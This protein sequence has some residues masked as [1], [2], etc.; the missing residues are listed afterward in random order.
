MKRKIKESSSW[1]KVGEM[2]GGKLLKYII[3][4]IETFD[5]P[6]TMVVKTGKV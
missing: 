2:E 6:S 4:N 1:C 5:T 3:K